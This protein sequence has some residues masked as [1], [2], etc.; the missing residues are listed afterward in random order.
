MLAAPISIKEGRV[1]RLD[2]DRRSEILQD[3]RSCQCVVVCLELMTDGCTEEIPS[4]RCEQT[5]GDGQSDQLFVTY[6]VISLR[7]VNV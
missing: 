3:T 4:P 1:R 6:M 7:F 2:N 5:G